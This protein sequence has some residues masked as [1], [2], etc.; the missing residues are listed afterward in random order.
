MKKILDFFGS[1]F[2]YRSPSKMEGFAWGLKAMPNWW[3]R[4]LAGTKKPLNKTKLIKL[5]IDD[6]LR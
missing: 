3:L 2:V 5:I 1:G 6:T 4:E